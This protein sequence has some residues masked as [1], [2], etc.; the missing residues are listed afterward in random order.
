MNS[1]HMLDSSKNDCQK[2]WVGLQPELIEKIDGAQKSI[3]ATCQL[4]CQKGSESVGKIKEFVLSHKKEIFFLGCCAITAFFAPHLFFTAAVV[5]IIFRVL[6]SEFLQKLAEN[7][8]QDNYNPF[9]TIPLNSLK[10]ISNLD[11]ALETIAAV[12]AVALGTIFTA[13]TWTVAL[14]PILGG[15]AAGNTAAKI[16]INIAHRYF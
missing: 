9:K 8:L 15:I 13:G 11:I 14:L 6:L 3:R 2:N 4:V 12:D 1:V 10:Y 7:V 5:T 16:G